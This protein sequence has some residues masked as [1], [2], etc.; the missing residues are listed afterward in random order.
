MWLLGA[1]GNDPFTSQLLTA[2]RGIGVQSEYIFHKEGST[3]LASIT[4]DASG[5]NHIILTERANGLLTIYNIKEIHE[6]LDTADI[7]LLQ[8]E[9]N[10]ETTRFVI[11]ESH[12]RLETTLY[13]TILLALTSCTLVLHPYSGKAHIC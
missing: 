8:N 1:D 4:V 6:V 7:V 2:I 11:A 13:R 3:G 10:W 9:I 12:K 5:E